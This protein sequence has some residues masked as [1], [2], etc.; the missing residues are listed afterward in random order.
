MESEDLSY[1][2]AAD[3]TPEETRGRK[4]MDLCSYRDHVELANT[5]N[6]T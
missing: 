4:E 2:D 6:D 3:N 1:S 5:K